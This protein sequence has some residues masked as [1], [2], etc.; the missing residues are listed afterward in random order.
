MLIVTNQQELDKVIKEVKNNP[1]NYFRIVIKN[2]NGWV[3]IYEYLKNSSVEAWGN[4]SVVARGNSSVEAWEN[5]SVEARG[6]SSVEARENSSV[7]AWE[8]SSVVAWENSSVEAW[9]NSSVVAW[10]NSSV[11]AWENSSVVARENSSVEAWGNV[12]INSYYGCKQ[13]IGHDFTSVKLIT[14][15]D[16]NYIQKKSEDMIIQHCYKIKYNFFTRHGIDTDKK[17]H[18]LFKRVSND[19]KTQEGCSWE[20]K[21][22]IGEQLKH[23]NWNPTNGECS[24]GKFHACPRPYFCDE[25]R[26]KKDD[27]YIAIKIHIDDMFDWGQH[28]EDVSY[29]HKIAFRKGKVLYKCDKFGNKIDE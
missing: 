6:N 24:S 26:S 10:G 3:S 1:D 5:S 19:F 13:I 12:N 9:G 22:D 23:P 17:Y 11:V 7:V 20:T 4:S 18:I 21:W 25:F 28:S 16:T 14:E 2:T 8:N 29:P 15:H 27:K